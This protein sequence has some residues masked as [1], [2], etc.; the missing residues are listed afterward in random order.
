MAPVSGHAPS[1]AAPGQHTVSIVLPAHNEE[2][3]IGRALATA[4]AAGD[5]LFAAHEVIVVD[6]GC[7]DGTAGIVQ[8]AAAADPRIRLVQHD[9]NLGYGEALRTGF[10]SATQELIFLTDS[11]NQFDLAELERFLPWIDRVDIVAGYRFDRQDTFLRKFNA[12]AWNVLVRAL[13]Y[14]PVRDIDCAF[15]LFRR[16]IFERVDLTSIGAMVSTELM[17][18]LGRSGVSIVELGVR[19]FP[20]EAGTP[21]GADPRVI[22][23]AFA[24]LR[25][26]YGELSRE[27]VDT[28]QLDSLPPG[29]DGQDPVAQLAGASMRT[30]GK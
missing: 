24:E 5:R 21:R 26:M 4:T 9:R 12:K 22:V 30:P 16:S 13:F 27:G 20:R 11:D 28:G 18:K 3:N 15:K 17:V 7:T 23:R 10:R 1:S 19:H 29:M 14:V 2:L 25:R 8:T 6:D